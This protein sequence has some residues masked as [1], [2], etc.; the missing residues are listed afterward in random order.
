M[1]GTQ[2]GL[3][4]RRDGTPLPAVS[5]GSSAPPSLHAPPSADMA[6]SSVPALP[7]PAVERDSGQKQGEDIHA[8]MERCRLHNEKRAQ[9][10]SSE[11]RKR[12]LA[13]ELHASKGG[14]PG[15]KGARVFIWDEEDGGFFI[16]RVFNRTD[17]AD[18]W[19]E[20]TP[21]QRIYNSF[22][23]QWDLCTALAPSEEAE[24]DYAYNDNEDAF[25]QPT[26]PVDIFPSIPDV[27]GHEAMETETGERAAQVLERAYNL[28]CEDSSEDADKPSGW[29]KQDV[30]STISLHFGFI[31]PEIAPSSSPWM[32]DKVC[33]W[34]VGHE[35][36]S[37]PETSALLTLLSHILEGNLNDAAANLC[38]LTS[39]DSDLQLD[40]TFNVK[41]IRQRD[42]MLYEIHPRG[43]EASGPSIL[44]ESA[45][46]ILQIIR[47]GWG[48]DSGIESIIRNLVELGAEFHP[49]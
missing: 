11:A 34:V 47:S 6:D 30:S 28:D 44:L 16:R 18:C 10:E 3:E 35:T 14:A 4:K 49:S 21:N 27:P 43:S 1:V 39:P 42:R 33:A 32:Q 26:S 7:F 17:A 5:F 20:F 12:H 48:Y 46:T 31:E 9:H 37:V 25:H 15:K 19:D 36:W 2:I 29:K 40:W 38:D 22:S 13:Q 45:A 23:N 8:F 24:S 41:T